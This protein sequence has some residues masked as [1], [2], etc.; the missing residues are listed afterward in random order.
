MEGL[1][2]RADAGIPRNWTP[3]QA[4]ARRLFGV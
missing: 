3:K 1:A 4:A 2:V